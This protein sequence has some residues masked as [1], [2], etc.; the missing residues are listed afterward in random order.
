LNPADVAKALRLL[1]RLGLFLPEADGFRIEWVTF[2]QPAPP[3]GGPFDEP[4]PRTHPQFMDAAVIDRARAE[5]ALDLLLIGHYDLESDFPKM[6]RDLS[7]LHGSEDYALLKNKVQKRRDRPPSPNRWAETWQVFQRDQVRRTASIHSHKA[8]LRLETS[9]EATTLLGLSITRPIEQVT[10]MVLIV[11]AEWPWHLPAAATLQI[12]AQLT[13]QIIIRLTL[14]SDKPEVRCPLRP[15]HWPLAGQVI[16]L[17]VQAAQP[18][19]A[20]KIEAW[21]E[22]KLRK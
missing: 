5:R 7:F 6:F 13:E 4:D 9:T 12:Q 15:N 17:T 16:S 8:R 3:I 20:L 10:A 1:V 21:L 14:E 11:R 22:A 18:H 2:N 19:P